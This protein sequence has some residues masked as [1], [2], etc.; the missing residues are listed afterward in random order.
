MHNSSPERSAPVSAQPSRWSRLHASLAT[1]EK[2]GR[3]LLA[4]DRARSQML[5]Y[6]RRS[7]LMSWPPRR[8]VADELLMAP[9][10]LRVADPSFVDELR[11]GN[12]GLAGEIADLAG[13]SPFARPRASEEWAREL[14]GFAWLRHLEAARSEETELLARRLVQ[15]WLQEGYR[16]KLHAWAPE[17]TG[18]RLM[19]WLAHSALLLDG[20]DHR[21]YATVLRS[22]QRQTSYLAAAWQ[23]APEGYSKLL[24]LVGL[25][26]ADVCIAGHDRQ[27]KRSDKLLAA[28]IER[29]ILADGGHIGRNP[30]TCVELVLDLL[31]LRQCFLVRGLTPNPALLRALG[32]MVPMLRHLRLGDGSLARFNGVGATDRDTLATV[33]AYDKGLGALPALAAPSAYARLERGATI[34]VIDVGSPPPLAVAQTAHAGCLSFELSV[35]GQPLFVNNGVPAL[36]EPGL[37]AAA[38]ATASH[39]TLCV[40]EQSSSK[41]ARR[42]PQ[43]GALSIEHPDRV[44]CS[45]SEEE[46]GLVLEAAHDGYVGRWGLLHTRCLRLDADGSKLRGSDGLA[47]AK[48][49]LRF[50]WDVP[51]AVHFHVHPD[52][53]VWPGRGPDSADLVFKSGEHWR[54]SAVGGALTIESSVHNAGALGPRP[55]QQ[56]VL[57]AACHGEAKVAWE[58]ERMPPGR[59]P[60][61]GAQAATAMA[62]SLAE[63]LATAEGTAAPDEGKAEASLDKG[64]A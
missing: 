3:T 52:V 10:D 32:Q 25:V 1:R 33:L 45:V 37:R 51:F 27:L 22:L 40:K 56:L 2:V 24:A 59:Q 57:R 6:V 26:L 20:A 16:D 12:F 36:C 64:G 29:Q 14:H 35:G 61:H 19:S 49:V 13:H 30:Q 62:Q 60:E 8:S 44:S 7:E 11:V 21:F 58:I 28:E 15:D 55:A 47:P 41:L 31:P 39:N 34:V 50:A 9:P 42:G 54:L 4:V 5:A 18:R 38:R 17:V 53:Q 63:R 43:R 23:N 46:G 48:G